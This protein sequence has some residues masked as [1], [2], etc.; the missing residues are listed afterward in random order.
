ML[1]T[2]NKNLNQLDKKIFVICLFDHLN[3][4]TANTAMFFSKTL[5]LYPP[6]SSIFLS[7]SY[8]TSSNICLIY[9]SV[10]FKFKLTETKLIIF[11]IRPYY[12]DC[13]NFLKYLSSFSNIVKSCIITSFLRILFSVM[14]S[15]HYLCT[16]SKLF[17]EGHE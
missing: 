13:I 5:F 9:S 11:L 14:K 10:K 17:N 2:L 16:F 4:D 8:Q 6:I 12:I 7:T 1:K 15:V 3:V